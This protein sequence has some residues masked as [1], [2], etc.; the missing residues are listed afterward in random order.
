MPIVATKP[1]ITIQNVLDAAIEAKLSFSAFDIFTFITGVGQAYASQLNVRDAFKAKFDTVSSVAGYSVIRKVG[2][3]GSYRWAEHD[4][5]AGDLRKREK[6]FSKNFTI[7][8]AAQTTPAP[9]QVKAPAAQTTPAPAQ[10]KKDGV[11][12]EVVLIYSDVGGNNNKIWKGVL[13]DNGDVYT[14]WGRVGKGL[15]TKT[16]SNAGERKLA[17]KEHE[18]LAKGYT[19]AQVVS[20]SPST[21]TVQN[22]NLMDLAIKQ[23][24]KGEP[25][26]DKLVRQL[27]AANIH[28]ITSQSNITF[29]ETT[30]VFATPLGVVTLS[31]INEAHLLLDAISAEV[32]RGMDVRVAFNIMEEVNRYLRLIPQD[33]GMRLDIQKMFPDPQAVLKQRN[34]LDSLEASYQLV[35]APTYAPDEKKPA[36]EETLFDLSLEAAGAKEIARVGKL[37]D[38]TRQSMHRFVANMKVSNVYNLHMPLHAAAFKAH[39]AKLSNQMELWHG[40]KMANILNILRTGLKISPPRTANRAGAMFGNGVYF[41]DQSTKSLNYATDYWHGGGNSQRG[42]FM[43]LAAV[44]MGNY[45]VPSGQRSSPPPKGYDSYFAQARKSGVA[46]NEMIVFRED[47]FLLTRLVEFK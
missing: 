44:A 46:N 20:A 8:P 11:Q 38:K 26:L 35:T 47:Q 2:K 22:G 31:A 34:L 32:D 41:S 10:V 37:F 5:P 16:Y 15:Q 24:S 9:A 33:F 18:K 43:F 19:H 45:H 25:I 40:T 39:G 6:S 23:I 36:V 17:A 4:T 27:V 30:G 12:R 28:T 29:N 42:F 3:E 13:Y 14:E 21:R 1:P 7:T